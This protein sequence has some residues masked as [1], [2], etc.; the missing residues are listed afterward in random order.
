MFLSSTDLSKVNADTLLNDI[1]LGMYFGITM[2]FLKE[3]KQRAINYACKAGG[4]LNE[5][6]K[7][8]QSHVHLRGVYIT[9]KHWLSHCI[10]FIDLHLY[11]FVFLIVPHRY[12]ELT[13]K[14]KCQTAK[15]MAYLQVM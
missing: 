3:K 2:L 1:L 13:K 10:D 4:D 9:Y 6:P 12:L 7:P 8:N 5:S 11:V 15:S 14:K